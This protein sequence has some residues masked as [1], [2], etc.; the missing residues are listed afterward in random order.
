M[1]VSH[2]MWMLRI[3]LRSSGRA[4]DNLSHLAISQTLYYIYLYLFIMCVCLFV[5]TLLKHVSGFTDGGQRAS[6]RNKFSPSSIW[7]SDTEP[8]LSC[9]VSGVYR[10]SLGVLIFCLLL[11]HF[12]ISYITT[13]SIS[14]VWE[15]WKMLSLLLLE[16]SKGCMNF[17]STFWKKIM[18][19]FIKK[20]CLNVFPRSSK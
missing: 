15:I 18:R 5:C 13:F 6:Y 12:K 16:K 19:G 2:M 3:E 9:L 20:D 7:I 11:E 4:I 8:S 14:V 1:M 17:C 10:A